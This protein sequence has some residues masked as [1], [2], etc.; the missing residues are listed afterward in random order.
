[1]KN[2]ETGSLKNPE[3][4]SLKNPEAGSWKKPA[5]KNSLLVLQTW[6]EQFSRS[7]GG[8]SLSEYTSDNRVRLLEG[9]RVKK[10]AE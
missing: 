1:L 9:L 8:N 3:T 2:P 7:G 6:L 10:N 5:Q 4:G